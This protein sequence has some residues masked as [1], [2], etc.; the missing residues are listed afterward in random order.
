MYLA[1][2]MAAS[3]SVP[4]FASFLAETRTEGAIKEL[5]VVAYVSALGLLISSAALL[6]MS[7]V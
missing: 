5:L 7:T 2:V 4:W 3:A 1:T 6:G